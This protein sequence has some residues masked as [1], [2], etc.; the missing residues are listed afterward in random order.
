MRVAYDQQI[1]LMQRRGGITRYVVG[2]IGAFDEHPELGVSADLPFRWGNS[3]AAAGLPRHGIRDLR[4]RAARRVMVPLSPRLHGRRYR[5][6]DLLHHTF[7]HPRY[8]TAGGGTRRVVTVYDMIPELFPDQVPA[9]V[10]LAKERYVRAADVVLA[11]SQSTRRDVLQH[12][13]GLTAPVLV[14][15]LGVD[16]VFA[17]GGP[18]PGG[19]SRYVLY[20]GLRSGYKDFAVL[21]RAVAALADRDVGVLA[22]GGGPW[23]TV[24]RDLLRD[25]DL[26]GR[27]SQRNLSD[28]GLAGAYQ[29]AAVVVVPSR[30]EGFGLPVVE[31]MSAGAPVVAADASSLPEVGGAAVRYFPPGDADALREELSSVLGDQTLRADMVGAGLAR[32]KQFTWL[33]TAE[34]TA[35]A[36]ATL[37]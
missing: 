18:D 37:R 11:I 34:A 4:N 8:L 14:T 31:A 22:A 2:L 32:A 30:Y 7:Y 27:A 15:P 10:H 26:T 13:P 17:A 16:P 23:T 29:H 5:A 25:L 19:G 28:S 20:I 36:Y 3:A 35:A 1:F 21:L 33:R 6:A 24:E 12:Y 9:G